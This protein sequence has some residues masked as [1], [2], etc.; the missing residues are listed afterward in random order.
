[1]DGKIDLA[2]RR[3]IANKLLNMPSLNRQ[4][5]PVQTVAKWLKVLNTL[6]QREMR[7]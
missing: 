7:I 6:S 5:Q 2:N 3:E 1:M 4:K